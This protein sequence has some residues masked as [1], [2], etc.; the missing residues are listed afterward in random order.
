MLWLKSGRLLTLCIYPLYLLLYITWSN[1]VEHSGVQKSIGSKQ[2]PSSTSAFTLLPKELFCGGAL[3]LFV[4]RSLCLLVRLCTI[5]AMPP[6]LLSFRYFSSEGPSFCLDQP[7]TV[8]LLPTA[9]YI[10]GMFGAHHYTQFIG[11]DESSLTFC[12]GQPGSMILQSSVPW[13]AWIA[14]ITPMSHCSQPGQVLLMQ[15][16][17]TL[18]TKYI[19]VNP[20]LISSHMRPS[21]RH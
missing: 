3:L 1:S 17:L 18:H 6:A 5:W 11:W 14:G 21:H 12:H 4:L 2:P 13:V 20:W 8:I 19:S 16:C 10:T 15:P 9:S 7:C